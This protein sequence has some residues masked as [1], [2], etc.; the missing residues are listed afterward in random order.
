MKYKINYKKQEGG[1]RWRRDNIEFKLTELTK[2]I[3]K[4][5]IKKYKRNSDLKEKVKEL[6]KENIDEK[7]I[8]NLNDGKLDAIFKK[9]WD[10]ETIFIYKEGNFKNKR[11]DIN[12][13]LDEGIFIKEIHQEIIKIIMES[14]LEYINKK[15]I[16]LGSIVTYGLLINKGNI[17][18]S[19]IIRYLSR[20]KNILKSKLIKKKK[21]P[22]Y[23]G[24]LIDFKDLDLKDSIKIDMFNENNKSLLK[25]NKGDNNYIEPEKILIKEL[26]IGQDYNN[27]W[28]IRMIYKTSI[29]DMISKIN[30]KKLFKEEYN[31]K[32][33]KRNII[34]KQQLEEIIYTL[35]NNVK[36]DV[37]INEYNKHK[38]L[39][40]KEIFIRYI[41]K[42]LLEGKE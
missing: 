41:I 6:L 13:I 34:K 36:E 27:L 37:L 24:I 5:S 14:I 18:N 25:I 1:V 23:E 30:E 3:I 12:K 19:I 7:I 17:L 26:K 39:V 4:D 32:E 2:K 16:K 10:K 33:R 15:N 8:I 29:E 40:E 21:F 35:S 38:K 42:Y 31:E 11:K 20:I 22:Y 9:K 28:V